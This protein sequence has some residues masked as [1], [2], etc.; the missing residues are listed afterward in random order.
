MDI[1]DEMHEQHLMHS[2]SVGLVPK[3]PLKW[4][5]LSIGLGILSLMP[6]RVQNLVKL[7]LLTCGKLDWRWRWRVSSRNSGWMVRF[8]EKRMEDIMNPVS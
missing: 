1:G 4:D 6:T 3:L 5:T 7:I 2:L 8:K